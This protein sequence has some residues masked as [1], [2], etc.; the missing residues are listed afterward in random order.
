MIRKLCSKC[1]LLRNGKIV[2]T[3]STE[4]VIQ[5]YIEHSFESV[6]C[7][8]SEVTDREG[9]GGLVFEKLELLD[10]ELKELAAAQSG[11]PLVVRMH[12]TNTTGKKYNAAR[13]SLLI[14]NQDHQFDIT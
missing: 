8:L 11:A 10:D 3:G 13:F 1:V 5:Q 6:L 9:H 14:K 2:T 7:D 12:F 4:E